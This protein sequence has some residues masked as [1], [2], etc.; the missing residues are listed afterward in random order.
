LPLVAVGREL[1]VVVLAVELQKVERVQHRVRGFVPLWSA[2][3][4]ATPSVPVTTASPSSVN[5]F[6]RSFAAIAGWF[7]PIMAAAREQAYGIVIDRLP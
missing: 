2:W 6:A 3:N 1:A 5:D 4:T 7:G